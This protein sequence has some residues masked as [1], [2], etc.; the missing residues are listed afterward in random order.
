MGNSVNPILLRPVLGIV[1][2]IDS[3]LL[4]MEQF[5]AWLRSSH[6]TVVFPSD[7]NYSIYRTTQEQASDMN[8]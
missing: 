8:L 5:I 2:A 6:P 7:V 4:S 3:V 1:L